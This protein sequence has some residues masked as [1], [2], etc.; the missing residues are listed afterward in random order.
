MITL[1]NS[2]KTLSFHCFIFQ[3]SML[4]FSE[5]RNYLQLAIILLISIGIHE[6]AHAYSSYKLGDPTPKIQGRLTPNPLKHIDPIGFLMIFLI[7]FG[8][9]KPVQIDPSYY[10]KPY[11]DELITALAGPV[12][13]IVLGILGILILMIYGK[14]LGTSAIELFNAAQA[15][16]FRR[17]LK[18]SPMIESIHQSYRECVPFIDTDEFMAPHIAKSVEF[19]RK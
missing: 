9:G 14:L 13:N 8:R 1:K 6:F 19:L 4:T 3:V 16:E 12:S 11:R 5:V 18:S 10:K 15:L 17:P 7:H 2:R